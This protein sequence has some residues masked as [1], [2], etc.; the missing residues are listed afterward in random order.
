MTLSRP[1]LGDVWSA[2]E[3]KVTLGGVVEGDRWHPLS[4][5]RGKVDRYW[6]TKGI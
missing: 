4:L 5:Q 1:S 2:L 6:K 3:K